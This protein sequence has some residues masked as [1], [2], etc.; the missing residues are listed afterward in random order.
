MR[1]LANLLRYADGNVWISD[2]RISAMLSHQSGGVE[3]IDFHGLQPVSRNARL[4][5]HAN[6][7]VRFY[8]DVLQDG[9]CTTL[10]STW[11]NIEVS[12]AAITQRWSLAPARLE[13]KVVLSRNTLLACC[14]SQ[15]A[16][17]SV[18][19]MKIQ[20]RIVWNAASQTCA[21]H[22]RRTWDQI[23]EKGPLLLLR[24]N[25]R[26]VL[27]E[28]LRR[29]G[30]Y[31]GDFLIPEAWRRLLYSRRCVSGT[32]R[33]EDLR[34]E[35][36]DSDMLLYDAD[37][38]IQLGGPGFDLHA[39]ADQEYQFKSGFFSA[40]PHWCSPPFAIR[41]FTAEPLPDDKP[42]ASPAVQIFAAQEQ[43]YAERLRE[44]PSLE[45]A[46]YPAVCE[47]FQQL[48]SIV[49]SAR[50]TDYGMTRA[51]PGTYYWIWAWDNLVTTM[52]QLRWGDV[53]QA[54]R[55]LDFVRLH[56]DLDGSI[57]GRWTRHLE[58]MDS[59]G[60]GAMDFLYSELTMSVYGET[61]DRQ[62]LRAHYTTLCHAFRT[63]AERTHTSG[64]FPTIGM[65]PDLPRK[66]GRDESYYVAIDSGAWYAQC[67][68]M[69]HIAW[70]LHD[71]PTARMA[72]AYA[73]RAEAGFL[74]TFW[75]Q[76]AGF[77]C[78]S[79]QPDTGEKNRTFPIFSLLCIESSFGHLLLADR[80]QACAGFLSRHLLQERGL[81]MTPTWDRHHT[82]E[83]AMSAWY[84]HWDLA[85][86][87]IWTRCG[88]RLSIQRW[89]DLVEQTFA[90]L[91]YCPEF[92]SLHAPDQERW[93]HHGA[94][95][96]LNC[97]T[98]WYSALLSALLGLQ[99]DSSGITL[100]PV[101]S[102]MDHGGR[103]RHAAVRRLCFRGGLWDFESSGEGRHIIELRVDDHP[104]VGS[105][106]IP[107]TCY[108]PGTHRVHIKYGEQE[109]DAPILAE[110]CGGSVRDS[111]RNCA[112]TV[113]TVYGYGRVDV[114]VRLSSAPQL[115]LDG[116]PVP[117]T[118]FARDRA[119][120]GRLRLAGEHELV[121]SRK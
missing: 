73:D 86:A 14:T 115:L 12:P 85:A 1:P 80:L 11:E 69:A 87:K 103:R 21:V 105:L 5:H 53:G 43:R 102:L 15:A 91:G 2:D 95:W 36:R 56:R 27:Q 33:F 83:P 88:D 46:D 17:A 22:G 76:E 50:V 78:D 20:L 19:D 60:Y 81:A 49:E 68:N 16:A 96:N 97:A 4:L 26:I 28:W 109:D 114:C 99:F 75:D 93:Q 118:W 55:V 74:K 34:P 107:S 52:S 112:K 113:V 41:F 104:V 79:V 71:E 51:C 18:G 108:T 84:P 23:R 47:F 121:I 59:R 25:D 94:A 10:A 45:L 82:S 106:K 100:L 62:I 72:E 90:A 9:V 38:W 8:I 37:T 64:F 116:E 89:L 111:K 31:Q 29:R 61:M 58:P 110:C 92:L 44:S 120:W 119:A 54:G 65:Y 67:R 13:L 48:P 40:C 3:Q 35:Y 57:P 30:D 98:G 70:L 24:A 39:L 101:P 6:A 63:L 42:E 77:L 66:M 117:V 32:A 7:A